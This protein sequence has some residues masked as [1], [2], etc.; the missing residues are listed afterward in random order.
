MWSGRLVHK[1][2]PALHSKERKMAVK[3]CP[4]PVPSWYM[5]VLC[6]DRIMLGH[7]DAPYII[8]EVGRSIGNQSIS[9]IYFSIWFF[10]LPLWVTK[11]RMFLRHFSPTQQQWVNSEVK[12][13]NEYCLY[14]THIICSNQ[15]GKTYKLLSTH[16][17]PDTILSA[18]STFIYFE[19]L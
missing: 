4:S 11:Q 7:W 15:T 9:P 18:L 3:E 2:S 13:Q 19:L 12:Y 5:R 8:E 1:S 10:F 14:P 17:L 6:T 16:S